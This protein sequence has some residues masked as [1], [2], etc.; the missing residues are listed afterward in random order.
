[1]A[2]KITSTPKIRSIVVSSVQSASENTLPFYKKL[3]TII[4]Q[5]IGTHSQ[6]WYQSG[7]KA[8]LALVTLP[9][10]Y[11]QI[12]PSTMQHYL[13]LGLLSGSFTGACT[14]LS[15]NSSWFQENEWKNLLL[16]NIAQF[17]SCK[18]WKV[19]SYTETILNSH[20]TNFQE[21]KALKAAYEA[22]KASY[23]A[24]NCAYGAGVGGTVIMA[25]YCLYGLYKVNSHIRYPR[26]LSEHPSQAKCSSVTT[27][28]EQ[29]DKLCTRQK[30][31]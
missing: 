30:Y 31:S 29:K 10:R 21:E 27:Q 15:C 2:K 1:M 3:Y 16:K 26:R 19:T 4:K 13:T 28:Q 6:Y 17:S 8:V 11:W 24:N 14:W 23:I 12:S 7:L 22:D 9:I 20:C 25:G 5:Y 18:L